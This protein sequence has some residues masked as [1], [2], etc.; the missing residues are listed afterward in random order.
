[1]TTTIEAL[2]WRYATKVFDE[3]EKLTN[4]QLDQIVEIVRLTPSSMGILPYQFLLVADQEIQ[5]KL[6]VASYGQKQISSA[7]AL[8]IW[9][10]G[11]PLEQGWIDRAAD[12]NIEVRGLDPL[13]ARSY[14]D[15]FKQSME[16][17][18]REERLQWASRQAYIALGSLM[19]ALAVE[20]IDSCPMEGFISDQ[21]NHI[22]GLDQRG[23]STIVVLAIGKRSPNDQT[24]MA[25]KV[26]RPKNEFL[27]S[28]ERFSL[29]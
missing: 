7:A 21:Y 2:N 3:K 23:L 15:K 5:D 27:I 8:G 20:G 16:S 12:L 26:R 19:T 18:S 4:E 22:L 24:A 6:T 28:D 17:K 1:M 13:M 11:D 25:P 29:V 14:M 9:V 10:I